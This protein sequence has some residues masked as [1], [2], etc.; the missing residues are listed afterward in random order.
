MDP[1]TVEPPDIAAHA[2]IPAYSVITPPRTDPSESPDVDKIPP[3]G[4]VIT[5]DPVEDPLPRSALRIPESPDVDELGDTRL[6]SA[7]CI[8]DISCDSVDCTPVPADVLAAWALCA[9]NPDWLVVCGAGVN[10]V[11]FAVLAVE[12]A[13]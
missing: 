2:G 5:D 12:F 1:N 11:T 10:C 6:C 7:V 4:V 9:A 13:A 8:E 3:P